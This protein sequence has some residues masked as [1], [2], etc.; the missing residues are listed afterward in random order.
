MLPQDTTHL[1]QRPCPT[2]EEVR[3]KIQQAIGPHEDLM[4]VVKRRKLQ[5]Y[6]HVWPKPFCKAQWKGE[7]DKAD[8]GRGGKKTSGNGQAWYSASHRGQWSTGK[9]G[10]DW[11]GNHLRCPNDPLG[12]GIND[13]D[14]NRLKLYWGDKQMKIISGRRMNGWKLFRGNK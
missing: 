8:R 12:W 2:N 3:A 5:W 4:T 9:N 14:D 6:G 11:L 10:G 7:E 13:D 1:M